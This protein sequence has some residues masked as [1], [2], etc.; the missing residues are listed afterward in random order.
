MINTE[1]IIQKIMKELKTLKS[2]PPNV[3]DQSTAQWTR[4]V[5]TALCRA[6]RHLGCSA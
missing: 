4:E 1:D 2:K 3:L 6:R 5:L